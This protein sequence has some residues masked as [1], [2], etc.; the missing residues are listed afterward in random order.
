MN[1]YDIFIQVAAQISLPVIPKWEYAL[2]ELRPRSQ[3]RQQCSRTLKP[4]IQH[5]NRIPLHRNS[6]ILQIFPQRSIHRY[7]HRQTF[8]LQRHQPCQQRILSLQYLTAL[9][10]IGAGYKSIN[11]IHLTCQTPRKTVIYIGYRS[12]Y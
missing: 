12:V 1:L 9:H 11:F 8:P 7:C 3:L 4:I 2:V 5:L 10:F 6:L